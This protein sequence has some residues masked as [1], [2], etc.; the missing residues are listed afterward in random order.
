MNTL[1]WGLCAL[2]LSGGP[3]LAVGSD[4]DTELKALRADVEALKAAKPVEPASSA[5]VWVQMTGFYDN[6][7][8]A[9][10]D[11][12]GVSKN[13]ATARS[14]VDLGLEGQ[15]AQ[16]LNAMAVFRVDKTSVDIFDL[17]AEQSLP[18]GLSLRA[19]YL[20]LTGI[21]DASTIANDDKTQFIRGELVDSPLLG[22]NGSGPAL[23]LLWQVDPSLY[24]Q[25]A[26][27]DQQGKAV[28]PFD[29]VFAFVE[30]GYKHGFLGGGEMKA[31]YRE[32]GR[33]FKGAVPAVGVVVDQTVIGS[34]QAFARW[35][36]E[37]TATGLESDASGAYSAQPLNSGGVSG[38]SPFSS[39]SA[40]LD[41]GAPLSFRPDDHLAAA[42]G[43]VQATDT[44]QWGFVEAYYSWSLSPNAQISLDYQGDFSR[45]KLAVPHA[46]GDT[47]A[48]L[49][50]EHK[51]VGRL[52]LAY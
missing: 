47:Y 19:G 8:G 38:T 31:W 7:V 10:D 32:T 28:S 1:R 21:L 5:K 46:W 2:L 33:G 29:E 52:N 23:R 9:G 3:L 36:Q 15:P 12:A 17:W 49:D 11:P 18:Y 42:W 6:T 30:A 27:Q 25:G 40:G 13:R 14:I 35:G 48:A 37:F 43:T 44:S 45:M 41:W 20:D 16:G 39:V 24:L 22:L 26:V 50:N 51:L 4:T 34:V